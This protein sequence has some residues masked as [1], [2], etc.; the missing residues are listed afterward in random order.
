[1]L[2]LSRRTGQSFTLTHW[3]GQIV[4][5][6]CVEV[7]PDRIRMAV[8]GSD[9]SHCVCEI[10]SIPLYRPDR[11]VTVTESTVMS[12]QVG[13]DWVSIRFRRKAS[14]RIDCCF[15]DPLHRFAIVRSEIANH[16][17]SDRSAGVISPP[18]GMD[19]I[20]SGSDGLT[21]NSS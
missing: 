7:T 16:M 14:D 11:P 4:R 10:Q 15:S 3:N 13:H 17:P 19:G 8:Q 12:I 5:L 9:E 6:D 2:V 20:G 18:D 21:K 1:M